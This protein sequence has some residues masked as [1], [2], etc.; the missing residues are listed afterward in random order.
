MQAG[1]EFSQVSLEDLDSWSEPPPF[2]PSSQ[3]L[4]NTSEHRI[5]DVLRSLAESSDPL[6]TR[7]RIGRFQILRVIGEGGMGIVYAA[8]DPLREQNVAIKVLRAELIENPELR[9]WF[10]R[11][12]QLLA[13]VDSCHV[14]RM[15]EFVE[16]EGCWC[17]VQE[18]V[19][20]PTLA[21]FVQ[22]KG[23][24]PETE[25]LTVMVNISEALCELHSRGIIHRD[26]KPDNILLCHR[27]NAAVSDGA[28]FRMI[29]KLA[30]FGVARQTQSHESVAI[31]S[32]DSLLGT[33]LYM[34]PEHFYGGDLVDQRSD[35][36][37]L[38]VTLFYCVTGQTPFKADHPL[39]LAEAHRHL[40]APN[41]QTI[42]TQ[43]SNGICDVIKK[44]LQKLPD[45]RY[46]SAVE[47]RADLLRLQ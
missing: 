12:A 32:A 35:L 36:Y 43:L 15:L 9:R 38:G 23:K 21:E 44:L 41:P 25:A 30:D 40:P 39:G 46:D 17:M 1:D 8:F 14:V 19:Q 7:G 27:D 13:A 4:V 45:L 31:I 11:E 6:L 26:I 18:L 22:S 16:V 24:V 29:A 3:S 2:V 42:N 33:P 10:Q 37:S 5:R 20:G 47:F 34:S 28:E